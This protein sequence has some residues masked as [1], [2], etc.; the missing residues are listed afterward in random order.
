M[1]FFLLPSA[2]KKPP[3]AFFIYRA[4]QLEPLSLPAACCHAPP[5]SSRQQLAPA[6]AT[7]AL[8]AGARV[9]VLF[10][11]RQLWEAAEVAEV[12]AEGQRAAVVTLADRQRRVLPLSS[13]ALSAHA[14]D[15][16]SDDSGSE[17]EQLRTG[18]G[19]SLNR[20]E[21][22]EDWEEGSNGEGSD[23]GSGASSGSDMELELEDE[24]AE[25]AG[26]GF[27]GAAFGRVSLAMS[28]AAELLQQQAE[29]GPQSSTR[30]FFAS[31]AHSRGIGSKVSTAGGRALACWAVRGGPGC[32]IC[33]C[34]CGR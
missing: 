1:P 17:G 20:G 2:A 28:E 26:E 29:A 15:P 16:F 33:M 31:E 23:S 13:V 21:E 11:G 27:G 12:D 34:R 18:G 32:E 30:L 24:E 22:E 6:V 25:E 14:P 10:E 3:I 7:E 19:G 8:H 5:S 4:Y 9:I